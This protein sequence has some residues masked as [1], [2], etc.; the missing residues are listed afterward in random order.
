MD[1]KSRNMDSDT[2][3]IVD[4]FLETKK[5]DLELA[6]LLNISASTV[7]RRLIDHDRITWVYN[8]EENKIPNIKLDKKYIF[9]I[10][11]CQLIE[12]CE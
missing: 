6:S 1:K 8:Q 4:L 7:G 9:S 5:S 2:K 10:K 3:K 11:N 12:F